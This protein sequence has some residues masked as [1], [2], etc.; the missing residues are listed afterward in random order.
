M[1]RNEDKYTFRKCTILLPIIDDDVYNVFWCFDGRISDNMICGY[2]RECSTKS[3]PMEIVHIIGQYGKK[4]MIHFFNSREP[5]S[6]FAIALD[7]IVA[8]CV[9]IVS[10]CSST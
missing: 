1:D 9:D 8:N 4:E 6:H 5:Q 3:I 10:E 2:L 7:D